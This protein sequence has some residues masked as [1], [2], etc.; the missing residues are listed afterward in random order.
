MTDLIAVGGSKPVAGLGLVQGEPG[1]L[2]LR[3]CSSNRTRENRPSGMI[4]ERGGNGIRLLDGTL[5]GAPPRYPTIPILRISAVRP[6]GLDLEDI[7]YLPNGDYPRDLQHFFIATED[8]LFTRYS[9]NPEFVGACAMVRRLPRPTL[10]PD[11]LIRAVVNKEIA[12]PAFLELATSAGYSRDYIRRRR[13]TTAGQTG[14][15]GSDLKSMPVPLPPLAEQARIAQEVERQFSIIQALS[16]A[17]ERSLERIASLRRGI[18]NV[19]FQGGLAP[20]DPSDEPAEV[21]VERIKAARA[22]HEPSPVHPRRRVR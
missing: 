3:T 10:H 16:C 4:V 19:A 8:L 1:R 12:E 22:A 17:G 9:G 6:L 2:P 7:R 15:S 13:R 21:L 5:I 14:I 18:L 20:H 11:K